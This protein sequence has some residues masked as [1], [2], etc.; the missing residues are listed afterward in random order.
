V[1]SL[2]SALA[3]VVLLGATADAHATFPGRNG[4]IAFVRGVYG[5]VGDWQSRDVYSVKPD[6]SGLRNLTR[7]LSFDQF[8]PA[9]SADGRRIAYVEADGASSSEIYGDE[10]WTMRADGSRKRRLT[11][12]GTADEQPAWSPDR[13]WIVFSRRTPH[14]NVDLAVIRSSGGRVR[15]LTRTTNVDE[16]VPAWSPDGGRIAYLLAPRVESLASRAGY[17]VLTVRTGR[18][19][20]VALDY[21]LDARPSWTPRGRLSISRAVWAPDGRVRVIAN[22]HGPYGGGT[23]RIEIQNLDGS[24]RRVVTNSVYP[25]DDYDPAW[26][27]LPRRKA[28]GAWVR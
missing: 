4:R 6:G 18:V 16:L 23:R 2:V 15:L 7:D 19:R 25:L 9:W 11:E 8:S 3:V 1:R 21:G 20:R 26:Q 27:P 13:K 5:P 10:L 14:G 17:Y 22:P 12:N 24:L 28:G